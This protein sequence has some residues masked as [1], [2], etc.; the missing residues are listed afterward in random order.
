MA[1]LMVVTHNIATVDPN[2]FSLVGLSVT[3]F[4]FE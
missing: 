2:D 4:I 3:F 1:H